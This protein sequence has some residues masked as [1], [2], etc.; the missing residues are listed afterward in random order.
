VE[1]KEEIKFSDL[2]ELTGSFWILAIIIMLS[3]ALFV[4]FLDNGNAFMQA[5]YSFSQKTAGEYFYLIKAS[6]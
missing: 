3:E 4:P 5:K 6:F 1:V 2:K